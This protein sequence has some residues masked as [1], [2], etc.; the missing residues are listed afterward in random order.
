[1]RKA[2][3]FYWLCVRRAWSGSFERANALATLLGGTVIWIVAWFFGYEAKVPESLGPNIFFGVLCFVAAWLVLFIVRLLGTPSALYWDAHDLAKRLTARLAPNISVYLNAR[4]GG[5][6]TL[7]EMNPLQKWIQITVESRSAAPLTDCEVWV[8][9]IQ[10]MDDGTV[11]AELIEESIR[12]LWSQIPAPENRRRNL[13]AMVPQAANLFSLQDVPIPHLFPQFDHVKTRLAEQIQTPGQYRFEIVVT[14][15][16]SAP[17]KK[18][19][20]FDWGGNFE[21]VKISELPCGNQ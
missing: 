14:A 7:E 8:N 11:I 13:P 1:M 17:A 12:A 18:Y 9:K 19:F 3:C 10:R 16:D 5:V 20:L 6:N 21:D 4:T 15:R 2:L